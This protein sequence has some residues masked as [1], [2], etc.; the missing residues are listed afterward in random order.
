MTI[1]YY[2]NNL[3]ENGV[4]IIL[5]TVSKSYGDDNKFK[6]FQK[7]IKNYGQSSLM[8]IDFEDKPFGVDSLAEDI[9]LFIKE[10]SKTTIIISIHGSQILPYSDHYSL[11]GPEIMSSPI[12]S[13]IFGGRILSSDVLAA[14]GKAAESKPVDVWQYTCQGAKLIDK[15]LEY[16]PSGSTYVAESDGFISSEY[17]LKTFTSYLENNKEIDIN[18]LYLDYL[19]GQE[20][21][22]EIGLKNDPIKVI[23]GHEKPIKALEKADILVQKIINETVDQDKLLKALDFYNER[24]GNDIIYLFQDIKMR[25]ENIGSFSDCVS[26][27][28]KL[29]YV[30]SGIL[31]RL[32]N[33]ISSYF[34]LNN[35][36]NC[37]IFKNEQCLS[38][39]GFDSHSIS[40]FSPLAFAAIEEIYTGLI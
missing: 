15:A 18:E 26:Q 2:G 38:E 28:K 4:I 40:N 13:M 20:K 27:E 11:V 36:D 33:T 9:K 7:A 8:T 29:N 10:H 31:Y 14:I 3:S 12:L 17:F 39:G 16:L 25:E 35:Y 30:T 37:P 32:V 1:N 21:T 6:I 19:L 22:Y 24:S 34:N 5:G 23:I